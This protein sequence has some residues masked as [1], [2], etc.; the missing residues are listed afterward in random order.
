[1]T[2][3]QEPEEN[4][5]PHDEGAPEMQAERLG[6]VPQ[7]QYK[8]KRPWVSAEE[9][10]ERLREDSPR[11]RHANDRLARELDDLKKTNEAILAHHERQIVQERKD[12][13]DRAT[14]DLEAKLDQATAA[15]DTVGAK[16]ILKKQ[17]ALDAQ[18]ANPQPTQPVKKGLSAEDRALVN[19]FVKDNSEW[20]GIDTTMTAFAQNYETKLK[21]DGVALEDRLQ[22]VLEKV[23][24]KFP[25]EFADMNNDALD[26][27]PPV[28]PRNQAPRSAPPARNNSSGVR[29]QPP[30]IEPGS[31]EALT[32]K[33]KASC[34]AHLK[35]FPDPKK[36]EQ[37]K[38]T[39]LK[40]A[41]NDAT[42]FQ[43]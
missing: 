16:A 10:L 19:S 33:A 6:W 41:R 3:Q 35:A 22:I 27:E 30:R 42:L 31:Y 21:N 34:D 9:Y 11:L 20:Y 37:A 1:M 40:F 4:E 17:Q 32:P 39:W 12:A 7:E 29:R 15:G 38:A 14:A 23:K 36:K 24:R 18:I 26:D 43:S 8:G 2:E 25:Q 5:I 28:P 13:Y